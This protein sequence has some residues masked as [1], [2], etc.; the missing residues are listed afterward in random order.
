MAQ[1]SNEES[2]QEDKQECS[3]YFCTGPNILTPVQTIFALII[4]TGGHYG[5]NS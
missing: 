1:G 5:G 2:R 4:P 3:S